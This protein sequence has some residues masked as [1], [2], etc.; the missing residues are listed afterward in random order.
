MSVCLCVC[1]LSMIL[2]CV[3]GN[4]L[5][6]TVY[7][8]IAT[9]TEVCKSQTVQNPSFHATT[10]DTAS[11][12]SHWP[13]GV[14]PVNPGDPSLKNSCCADDLSLNPQTFIWNDRGQNQNL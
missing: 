6:S 13:A 5:I 7:I 10:T 8:T 1:R 12:V 14:G 2:A 9:K 11:L 3:C 4:T